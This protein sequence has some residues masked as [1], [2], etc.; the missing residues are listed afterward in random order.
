MADA[1][2][3]VPAARSATIC[4]L[5]KPRLLLGSLPALAALTSR[6]CLAVAISLRE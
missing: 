3:G 4:R 2:Q 1:S 6:N 5:Q